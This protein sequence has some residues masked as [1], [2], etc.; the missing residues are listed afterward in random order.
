MD[1][2]EDYDSARRSASGQD[3]S[4]KI[5]E[6]LESQQTTKIYYNPVAQQSIPE[7]RCLPCYAL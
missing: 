7:V 3:L 5:D 2:D 6:A 4:A 1:I